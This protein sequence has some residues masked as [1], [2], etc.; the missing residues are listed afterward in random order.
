MAAAAA[1]GALSASWSWSG[2]F[3]TRTAGSGGALAAVLVRVDVSD[4]VSFLVFSAGG[5]VGG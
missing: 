2:G 1:S 5:F 4:G 3:F